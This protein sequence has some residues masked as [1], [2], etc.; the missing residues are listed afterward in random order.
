MNPGSDQRCTSPD[1]VLL[2]C[3]AWQP[4]H[5]KGVYRPSETSLEQLFT[6]SPK[7]EL[8]ELRKEIRTADRIDLLISF[9][10]WSGLR[11]ILDDLK[12]F[13]KR[14][15]LRVITTSYTGATDVKAVEALA[16]LQNTTVKISYDTE[17]TRLHAKTYTFRRNNG[18]STSY[19]GSSNLSNPAITSGLE[20]NVKIAGRIHTTSSGRSTRRLRPLNDPRVCRMRRAGKMQ[21]LSE[22]ERIDLAVFDMRPTTSE[23]DPSTKSRA[24]C[25]TT[26]KTSLSPPPGREKRSYQRLTTKASSRDQGSTPGCS[27]SLTVRRS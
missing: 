16:A 25:T 8:D 11:L 20:W 12:E 21:R 14:G 15:Q 24:E 1:A 10:K 22:E 26:T 6:G 17:R 2:T 13:V 4:F 5:G 7:S 18:F 19:L 23:G 27:S 3:G 9:I